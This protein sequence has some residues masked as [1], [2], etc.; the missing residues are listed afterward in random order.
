[1]TVETN[2]MKLPGLTSVQADIITGNVQVEGDI[3]PD[4]IR[5]TINA[6]GYRFVK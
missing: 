6:L 3:Q 1:M 2:L 4:K 5:D